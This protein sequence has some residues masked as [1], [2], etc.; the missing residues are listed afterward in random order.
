MKTKQFTLLELMLVTS[1]IGVISSMMLPAIASAREKAQATSCR[2]NLKSIGFSMLSYVHDNNNF[3]MPADFG[4]TNNGNVHHWLNYITQQGMNEKSQQCPSLSLEEHFD[5]AG[6]DPAT[7]NI[8]KHG[9]YI[10]NIIPNNQWG[11]APVN[12]DAL[13]WNET[14]EIPININTV[15]RPSNTLYI[16]D[17]IKNLNSNHIGINAF[18][19][20]DWGTLQLPPSGDVRRVGVQH[21]GNYN[22]LFGDGSVRLLYHSSA[23][24]WN[25]RQ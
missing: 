6:H 12:S 18:S 13:G 22:S 3:V 8:Y 14:P 10:M 7:G 5:P 23:E 4:D 21:Q 9:A 19:K 11:S 20:T 25:T 15:T 16:T 1:L 2:N 17:V 24:Q